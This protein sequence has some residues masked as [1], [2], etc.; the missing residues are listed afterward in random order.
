MALPEQ[1]RKQA[2]AVQELYKQLNA[3]NDQ[4]QQADGPEAE[5]AGTAA[6][7][8]DAPAPDV[9]A[10]SPAAPEQ[11]AGDDKASE[12]VAQKYRTL[13]GMYNAEVPR[14]HAQ[15]QGAGA[16]CPADGAAPGYHVVACTATGCGTSDSHSA[17]RHRQGC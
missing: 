9:A 16:A 3:E 15:N 8:A 7:A 17:P 6:P 2:E 11:R 1:I 4:G 10:P 12:D 5:D 13:Q 14:L